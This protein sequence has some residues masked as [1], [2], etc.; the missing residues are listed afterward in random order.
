[1]CFFI[2]F[3][4]GNSTNFSSSKGGSLQNSQKGGSGGALGGGGGVGIGGSDGADDSF[5]AL[6]QKVKEKMVAKKPTIKT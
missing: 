2:F 5:E 1:M 6:L 4:D 3:L